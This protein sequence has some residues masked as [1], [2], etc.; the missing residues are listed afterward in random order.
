MKYTERD[1][2]NLT[3]VAKLCNLSPV[4]AEENSIIKGRYTFNDA[5][6][7]FD[8][9]ACAENEKSIFKTCIKQLLEAHDSL[10]NSTEFKL[11]QQ[12]GLDDDTFNRLMGIRKTIEANFENLIEENSADFEEYTQTLEGELRF[13][14]LVITS[15]GEYQ[16]EIKIKRTK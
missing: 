11:P 8:L 6:F 1:Y 2:T 5:K 9:S 15:F 13:K 12:F 14:D 16:Y 7:Q 10:K 4:I 3:E